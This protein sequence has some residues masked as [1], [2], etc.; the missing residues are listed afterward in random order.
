MSKPFFVSLLAPYWWEAPFIKNYTTTDVHNLLVAN[1]FHHYKYNGAG[2]GCL[3]WTT[4][5][6]KLLE[7]EGVIAVGSKSSYEELVDKVRADSLYWVPEEPGAE[8]F[9]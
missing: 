9:D 4:A 8:F 7:D 5:L 3:T 1:K 6:I 2:S